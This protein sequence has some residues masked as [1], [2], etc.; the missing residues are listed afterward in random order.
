MNIHVPEQVRKKYPNFEFKGRTFNRNNRKLIRAVNHNIGKS[1]YYSFDE[2]F[3]WM[4]N[5][6]IP[7]WKIKYI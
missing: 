6:I 4:S 7:D 2:D 5:T 3:F 1:F